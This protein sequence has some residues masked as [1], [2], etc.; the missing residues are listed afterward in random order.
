M[1]Y[2]LYGSQKTVTVKGVSLSEGKISTKQ[3]YLKYNQSY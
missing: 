1:Q 2:N 3:A